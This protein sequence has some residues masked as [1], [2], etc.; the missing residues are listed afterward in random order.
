MKSETE[1][2]IGKNKSK[3]LNAKIIPKLK[4]WARNSFFLN[5]GATY[6]MTPDISDLIPGSLVE[7]DKYIK[8]SD[9]HFVTEKQALKFK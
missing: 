4:S 2:L 9:G 3:V 8:I 6:H 7:T 1:N 5:S